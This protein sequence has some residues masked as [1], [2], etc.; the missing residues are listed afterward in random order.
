MKNPAK[1]I[2]FI[3]LA[4]LA[5]G[6]IINLVQYSRTGV[7]PRQPILLEVVLIVVAIRLLLRKP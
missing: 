1:L 2:Y 5:S 4:L 7:F 3:A 6:L